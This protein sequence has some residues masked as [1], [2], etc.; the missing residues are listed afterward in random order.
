MYL[1]AHQR[2]T[3]PIMVEGSCGRS[4][5]SQRHW[6]LFYQHYSTLAA[7]GWESLTCCS[8]TTLRRTKNELAWLH[9]RGHQGMRTRGGYDVPPTF[10]ACTPQGVQ[11]NLRC[12]PAG[13]YS[14][15]RR[16]VTQFPTCSKIQFS[17]LQVCSVAT[18]RSV[19]N[20]KRSRRRPLP[21]VLF[22]L[23]A[24]LLVPLS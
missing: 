9:R 20:S 6:S 23:I 14:W 2:G 4:T 22:H 5:R 13:Y 21:V 19:I 16:K 1:Q 12:T 17:S 18:F 24:Y 10:A 15:P 11:R 3:P 8:L 7:T